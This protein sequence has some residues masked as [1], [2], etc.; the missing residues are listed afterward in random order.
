MKVLAIAIPIL[1]SALLATTSIYGAVWCCKKDGK[2]QLMGDKKICT[3]GKAA[4]T[5]DAKNKKKAKIAK[6][7]E[8]ASGEWVKK[9]AKKKS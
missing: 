4:P 3:K 8:E 9:A 5:K 2:V 1:L 7:C 6:A